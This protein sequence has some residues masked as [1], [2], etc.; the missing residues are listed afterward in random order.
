MSRQIEY[1]G[2]DI[3]VAASFRFGGVFVSARM[4]GGPDQVA[5]QFGLPSSETSV[6][7]ACDAAIADLCALVDRILSDARGLPGATGE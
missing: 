5:R 2:F 6:E 3:T 7:R 4:S 1:R